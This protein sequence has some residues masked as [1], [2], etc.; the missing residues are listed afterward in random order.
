MARGVPPIS[1][2]AVRVRSILLRATS[3]HVTWLDG[4]EPGG[5]RIPAVV[6]DDESGGP[7]GHLHAAEVEAAY[8]AHVAGRHGVAVRLLAG[9]IDA[10]LRSGVRRVVPL[11]LDRHGLTLRLEYPR[12]HR[13]VMLPFAG[14]ADCPGEVRDRMAALLERAQRPASAGPRSLA[15]LMRSGPAAARLC[16]PVEDAEE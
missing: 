2:P 4:P 11:A 8:L 7:C 12:A 3:A 13:D 15:A 6:L 14:P 16:A 9:L 10:R 5:G 1:Q